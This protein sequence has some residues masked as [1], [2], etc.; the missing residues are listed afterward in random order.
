MS[1]RASKASAH[2]SFRQYRREANHYFLRIQV[3]RVRLAVQRQVDFGNGRVIVR[4]KRQ[5]FAVFR[6]PEGWLVLCNT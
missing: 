4:H 6:E 5:M 3:E 1:I 2:F